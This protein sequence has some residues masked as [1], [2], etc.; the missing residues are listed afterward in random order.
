[1][2]FALQIRQNHDCNTFALLRSL[3]PML[4]QKFAYVPPTHLPTIVLPDLTR[5]CSDDG[6][7]YKKREG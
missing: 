1:M 5:S 4:Q 3:N 7:M 6:F 2:A